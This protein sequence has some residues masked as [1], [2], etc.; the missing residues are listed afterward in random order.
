MPLTIAIDILHTRKQIIVLDDIILITETIASRKN[1][2]YKIAAGKRSG[3]KIGEINVRAASDRCIN[4]TSIISEPC[5]VC[6][7]IQ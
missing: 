6:G 7:R 4:N 2:I 3:N 5:T 1:H